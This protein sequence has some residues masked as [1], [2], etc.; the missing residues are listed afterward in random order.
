MVNGLALSEYAINANKNQP[1][2]KKKTTKTTCAYCVTNCMKENFWSVTSARNGIALPAQ[3]LR[4]PNLK[5]LKM[6]STFVES[7]ISEFYL[8]MLTK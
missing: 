6:R 5:I 8:L 3:A 7:V 2:K 1:K 4:Q